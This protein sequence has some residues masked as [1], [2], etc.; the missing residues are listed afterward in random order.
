MID[1]IADGVDEKRYGD[2]R[3]EHHIV[4]LLP[5]ALTPDTAAAASFEAHIDM[6]SSAP[7]ALPSI[8]KDEDILQLKMSLDIFGPFTMVTVPTDGIHPSLGL[9]FHPGL[10]SSTVK[11]CLPKSPASAIN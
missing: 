11:D 1:L 10:H 9:L 8:N 2:S 4:H 3:I 6:T 7:S 5:T